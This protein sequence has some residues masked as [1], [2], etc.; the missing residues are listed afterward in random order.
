MMAMCL[1]LSNN[2]P[3][4]CVKRGYQSPILTRDAALRVLLNAGANINSQGNIGAT[5]LFTAVDV[6]ELGV[7]QY[8]LQV[9]LRA[10]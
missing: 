2:W 1:L 4:L 8:L 6:E 5:A 7:V 3:S 9:H 10:W